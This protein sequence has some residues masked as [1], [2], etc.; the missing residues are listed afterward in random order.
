MIS[1]FVTLRTK[2]GLRD[3]FVEASLSDA[4]GSVTNEPGCYRF[5]ILVDSNDPDLV[6]LYEVYEDQAALDTHR[7]MPHY[8]QWAKKVADWRE[9]AVGR[10]QCTTAFPSDDGWR[11]QKPHLRD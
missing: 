9:D 1:M 11:R 6:H 3:Q 8:V 4:R 5:D 2:P 10:I 7:T